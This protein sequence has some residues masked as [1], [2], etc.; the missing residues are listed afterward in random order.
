MLLA[1]LSVPGPGD[2][3]RTLSYDVARLPLARA[4]DLEGRPRLY[5]VA[6]DCVGFGN[7]RGA[8]VAPA[9]A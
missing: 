9:P 5:R 3:G 1:V 4:M 7:G 2:A 6:L 8:A